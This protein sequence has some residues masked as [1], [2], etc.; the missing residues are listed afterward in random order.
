[1]IYSITWLL[2]CS[3]KEQLGRLY[4]SRIKTN[5]L[6]FIL[7]QNFGKEDKYIVNVNVCFLDHYLLSPNA[8]KESSFR[9]WVQFLIF[10][11]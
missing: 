4:S 6:E 1:M 7:K 9:H 5:Y 3:N 10:V 2:Q 11:K 8:C